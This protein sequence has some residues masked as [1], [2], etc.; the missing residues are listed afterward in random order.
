MDH[1]CLIAQNLPHRRSRRAK[2]CRKWKKHGAKPR[3]R[4]YLNAD[5]E[6]PIREKKAASIRSF[7]FFQN[8]NTMEQN[9]DFF[10]LFIIFKF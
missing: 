8:V 5:S 4:M 10:V 3:N 1:H 7:K 2:M 9:Q 6:I